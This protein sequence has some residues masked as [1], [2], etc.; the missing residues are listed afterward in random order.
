MTVPA[1]APAANPDP[2]PPAAPPA[3]APPAAPPAAPAADPKPG[4]PPAAPASKDGQAPPAPKA[5]EK[6]ALT[7]PEGGR[8]DAQ[9]LEQI[10]A[11]ARAE[12]LS[13]E[14][15]QQRVDAHAALIDAQATRFHEETTADAV[16]GGTHLDETTK[17][18]SAALD[19]IRPAGTPRGDAFRALLHR[20]GYAN[21]LEVVS[22]LADLGKRWAEDGNA[23]GGGGGG[24]VKAAHEILYDAEAK[25][26]AAN[27]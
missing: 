15:A 12:G 25:K 19:K 26:A 21:N 14:A 24:D 16:Y 7:A 1:A 9:V 11:S 2:A 3:G 22:L 8:I 17:L 13:N 10:E 5:P 4:D 6:Y 20:T 27:S 18:A 23:G